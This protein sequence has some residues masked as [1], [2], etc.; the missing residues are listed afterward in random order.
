MNILLAMQTLKSIWYNT[1][2]WYICYFMQVPLQL[3]QQN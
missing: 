3:A 2:F 1:Y